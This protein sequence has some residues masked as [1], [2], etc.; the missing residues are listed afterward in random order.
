M[1]NERR[2]QIAEAIDELSVA[3]EQLEKLVSD[4]E[5]AKSILEAV[6]DEEMEAF[7]NLPQSL[8]GAERGE[9]M[10]T[11][12]DNLNEAIEYVDSAIQSAGNAKE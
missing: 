3:K 1:N 5:D 10:Q 11:A 2:T 8:Q 9:N 4:M 12:I 7:D 6:T